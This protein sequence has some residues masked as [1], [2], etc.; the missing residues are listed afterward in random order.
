MVLQ[1]KLNPNT[2][3]WEPVP[4]LDPS[5]FEYLKPTEAQLSQMQR[6]R[7]A[8]ASMAALLDITLP[9]GAD[10]TYIFRQ[11]RTLAMWANVCITRHADGAPRAEDVKDFV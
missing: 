5:T 11:L 10:K 1:K 2:M 4:Q 9:P 8:F 7:V 3:E 6:T